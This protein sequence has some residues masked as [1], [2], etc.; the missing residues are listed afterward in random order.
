MAYLM[1]A[2]HDTEKDPNAKFKIRAYLEQQKQ[3]KIYLQIWKKYTKK[4]LRVIIPSIE[5]QSL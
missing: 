3:L 4:I 1:Q 2:D 5:K